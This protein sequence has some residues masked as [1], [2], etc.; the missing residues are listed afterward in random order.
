MKMILIPFDQLNNIKNPKISDPLEYK[1]PI[2]HLEPDIELKLLQQ[3]KA[4][5]RCAVSKVPIKN[6]V[7]LDETLKSSSGVTQ[8]LKTEKLLKHLKENKSRIKYDKS[9]GELEFS[10][11]RAPE[12]DIRELINFLTTSRKK[13]TNP[14]GWDLFT[15]ALEGTHAPEDILKKRHTRKR[16]RGGDWGGANY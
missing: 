5:D 2:K 10:D 6:N 15:Q 12:S 3:Q 7:E 13:T 1:E 14:K 8:K 11:K 9:S 4:R 16:V